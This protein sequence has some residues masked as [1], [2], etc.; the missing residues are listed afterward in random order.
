MPRAYQIDKQDGAYFLTCTVVEWVDLF[1]RDNYKMFIAES[2]NFCIHAKGLDVY[3][4][5]IM[6]NHLHMVA[7]AKNDNLSSVIGDFKK[8]TSREMIKK[9][10][11]PQESRRNWMLPVFKLAG[12][13]N[14]RNKFF[15]V[16]Q[17]DNH[18]EE[19]Y[20]PS[21]SKCKIDYIHN[22]PVKEGFVQRP[23]DFLYSSARDYAGMKS[24]VDVTVITLY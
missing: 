14:P 3:S 17:Q 4:Y 10:S 20:S 5:V 6:P 12:E 7:S 16:W 24:P 19:V 1:T 22:N 13:S 18:A 23:E 15:Q 21:F 2:L 9:I 11:L 8:F